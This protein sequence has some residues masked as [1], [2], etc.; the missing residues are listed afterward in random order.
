[1]S[2]II[3]CRSGMA[4][5]LEVN[6]TGQ[7]RWGCLGRSCQ[8]LTLIASAAEE[9]V[10]KTGA[11]LTERA[12]WS[13]CELQL[14]SGWVE[15]RCLERLCSL[16]H[17][18]AHPPSHPFSHPSS[19]SSSPGPLTLLPSLFMLPPGFL[20]IFLPSLPGPPPGS[21]HRPFYPSSYPFSHSSSHP[22]SISSSHPSPH[23]L[24]ILPPPSF[25]S[26]FHLFA[27][28]SIQDPG[29]RASWTLGYRR[30]HSDPP[31]LASGLV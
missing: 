2:F 14:Q 13:Y 12:H 26:P 1:M 19:Q 17:S 29:P 11:W 24:P 23:L 4:V 6:G 16:I 15:V 9:T 21:A 30:E 20:S 10:S 18:S 28:L 7:G 27:S 3:H 5:E 25:Q 22:S 31:I 8:P